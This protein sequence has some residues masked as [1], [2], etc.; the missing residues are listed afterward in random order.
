MSGSLLQKLHWLPI[1]CG[2]EHTLSTLCDSSFSGTGPQY[3]SNLIQ[4]Y[5]SSR[6]LHSSSDTRI[7]KIPV[8]KTK[9]YDQSSF[10]YQGPTI[11]NNLPLAI[12]HQG[13]IDGLTRAL[14]PVFFYLSK[15]SLVYPSLHFLEFLD[16]T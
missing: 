12:R 4:V 11:W 13:R 1:S 3:L 5:T 8:V 6:C 15:H 10:A 9:S 14:K 16:I 7:L 2:I